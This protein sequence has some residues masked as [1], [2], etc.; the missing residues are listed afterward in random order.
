MPK[1]CVQRK[2]LLIIAV[3]PLSI[4]LAAAALAMM[5]PTTGVTKANVDRIQ[6]GMERAEV[7]EVLGE[8]PVMTIDQ[9]P[10]L[11]ETWNG[12]HGVFAVT[13]D[14]DRRVKATLWSDSQDTFFDKIGRWAH[15][16]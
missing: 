10:A 6:K 3:L 8:P 5:P 7:C 4:A 13:F 15:I 16:R 14:E 2:F 1:S 12:G 9:P 11:I